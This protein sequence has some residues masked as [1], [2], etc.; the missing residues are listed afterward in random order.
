MKWKVFNGK[1]RR[2]SYYWFFDNINKNIFFGYTNKHGIMIHSRY[3]SSLGIY[4]KVPCN[5]EKCFFMKTNLPHTPLRFLSKI[6]VQYY[7][8]LN[9]LKEELSMIQ[10][11]YPTPGIELFIKINNSKGMRI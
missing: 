4:S 11:K 2:N 6:H 5:S 3:N 1:K 8:S 10:E 9:I 7:S